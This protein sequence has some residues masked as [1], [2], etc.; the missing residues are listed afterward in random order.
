MS[1]T[2]TETRGVPLTRASQGRRESI[3]RPGGERLPTR[4]FA[5]FRFSCAQLLLSSRTGHVSWMLSSRR[6]GPNP[7][8]VP[9]VAWFLE[10]DYEWQPAA[11]TPRGCHARPEIDR[12]G[13]TSVSRIPEGSLSNDPTVTPGLVSVTSGTVCAEAVAAR[14]R[15][16]KRRPSSF[17][18]HSSFAGRMRSDEDDR[19]KRQLR[20]GGW[21]ERGVTGPRSARHE[22]KRSGEQ[23]GV[24]CRPAAFSRGRWKRSKALCPT[25]PR[26]PPITCAIRLLFEFRG[27]IG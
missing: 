14:I 15:A 19:S 17:S 20:R 26:W 11:R 6:A 24:V 27:N 4:A 23:D 1:I 25:P 2:G 7:L 21:R 16:S 8:S 22:R 12:V 13:A 10:K 18:W 9:Q 5:K 3:I